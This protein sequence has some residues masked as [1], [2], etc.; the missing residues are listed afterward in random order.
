MD[1][2]VVKGRVQFRVYRDQRSTAA[3]R[4]GKTRVIG[5]RDEVARIMRS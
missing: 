3:C 4:R 5:Q 1:F 2:R